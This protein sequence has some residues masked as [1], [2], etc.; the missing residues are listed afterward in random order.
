MILSIAMKY[1]LIIL[2]GSMLF[3][4][5][6]IAAESSCPAGQYRVKEHRRSGYTKSDGTI[7]RPT[8]VKSHCKSLTKVV[9]YLEQR[10]KKGVPSA[11][12]HKKELGES[13]TEEEKERLRDALEE[14][15]VSLLSGAVEGIYRLKKS[16]D[17]PNPASSA[18]GIIVL[19]D[20]AF[21]SSRNLG[22]IVTH[23]LSH[24]NYLDL[25]EKDRQDYRRATGWHL[26]LKPD[27]NFYWEGR[28]VGY[29]EDDGSF[30]PEEDY[31]N[32]LEHFLFGPDRLNKVTPEA[33]LWIKKRFG[34]NFKL[35]ER[36]K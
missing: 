36:K 7:V 17:Y 18:D 3:S 2:Y 27:R 14:T 12:P 8:T 30:S 25:S 1:S 26:E 16:K 23:E 29:I 35:K 5:T 4:L 11:W 20:T 31:A 34:E 22:E 10:F 24:Q 13:W 15:P 6:A 21:Q 28:K 32:N 33:Y 9:E 19:Y